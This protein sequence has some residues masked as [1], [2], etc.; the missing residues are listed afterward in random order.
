MVGLKVIIYNSFN[1]IDN[2][3]L[4]ILHKMHRKVM[5]F[6]DMIQRL[7]VE[8]VIAVFNSF[9]KA[10]GCRGLVDLFQKGLLTMFTSI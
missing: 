7:R 4:L 8:C 1:L 10:S 3:K 6:S 9:S 2:F 5:S